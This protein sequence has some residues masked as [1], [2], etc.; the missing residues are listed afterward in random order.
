MA[1][2]TVA[3]E[4]DEAAGYTRTVQEASNYEC[5]GTRWTAVGKGLECRQQTAPAPAPGPS[6]IPSQLKGLTFGE[7][8][9]IVFVCGIVLAAAMFG[10]HRRFCAKNHWGAVPS[11]LRESFLGSSKLP[12]SQLADKDVEARWQAAASCAK[13]FHAHP[14]RF[15]QPLRPLRNG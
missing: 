15:V 14:P 5:D 13:P 6:G 4:C 9:G 8:V 10:V 11:V 12:E 7:I 1:G 3:A 2:D